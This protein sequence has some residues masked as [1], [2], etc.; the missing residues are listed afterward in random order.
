M[1]D[2]TTPTN[3]KAK[4]LKRALF[5]LHF[6]G[7]LLGCKTVDK[8]FFVKK[9]FDRLF[10]PNFFLPTFF[11]PKN[12]DGNM[13]ENVIDQKKNNFFVPSPLTEKVTLK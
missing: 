4:M 8:F 12:I 5:L 7:I 6:V 10:R 2:H 13:K 3:P 11:S 9:K 1:A